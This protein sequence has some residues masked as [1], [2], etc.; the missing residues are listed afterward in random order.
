MIEAECNNLCPPSGKPP[1]MQ[2]CMP[3]H[4]C[5]L[6]LRI[7]EGVLVQLRT[8]RGHQQWLPPSPHFSPVHGLPAINKLPLP[9]A[10]HCQHHVSSNGPT[11]KSKGH[12]NKLTTK[13][14]KKRACVVTGRAH[15]GNPKHSTPCICK[16]QVGA[17]KPVHLSSAPDIGPA[18]PRCPQCG[19]PGPAT[20]H[21]TC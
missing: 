1:G 10:G 15:G 6:P 9:K 18:Q 7:V 20:G 17:I 3:Q 11:D 21:S 2:R 19:M 14:Q 4:A 13:R 12:T 16:L 8:K 5:M